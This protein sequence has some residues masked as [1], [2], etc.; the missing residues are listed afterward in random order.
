MFIWFAIEPDEATIKQE[1]AAVTIAIAD[2]IKYAEVTVICRNK[3]TIELLRLCKFAKRQFLAVKL[4]LP[5]CLY[6]VVESN[7]TQFISWNN[8][9]SFVSNN[10]NILNKF[11][12]DGYF[13][14]VWSLQELKNNLLVRVGICFNLNI[15]FIW[16]Y[17]EF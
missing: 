2:A 13:G 1:S 4:G 14:D 15:L 11:I 16:I 17:V 3:A 6:W 10:E 12:K 9:D 5:I 8:A 7:I